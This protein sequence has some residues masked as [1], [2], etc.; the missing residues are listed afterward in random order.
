M[1]WFV[2][3]SEAVLAAPTSDAP[4]TG[5]PTWLGWV[6]A[7]WVLA[8][9]VEF[10]ERYLWND[11]Q[12]AGA[13]AVLVAVDTACGLVRAW[14]TCTL[15]SRAFNRLIV[16]VFA[17]GAALVTVHTLS[18]HTLQGV[19]RGVLADVV[20]WLDAALYGAILFREVLSIHEHLTALGYPLLP[21]WV[22]RH[23]RHWHE[24][25]PRTL[26]RSAPVST[27]PTNAPADAEP[28]R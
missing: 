9:L 19:P 25:G 13:L 22:L 23:L 2:F 20:P 1:Q 3:S 7:G 8:P 6:A 28:P 24:H 12:F 26:K 21:P 4:G 18:H 27:N 5:A 14:H 15:N 11:W 16:K 10:V 17:Y